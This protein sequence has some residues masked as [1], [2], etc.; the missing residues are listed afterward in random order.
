MKVDSYGKLTGVKKLSTSKYIYLYARSKSD[1]TNVYTKARIKVKAKS[2]DSGSSG[3]SDD[4]DSSSLVVCIDPGHGGSDDGASSG[5]YDEKDIN[6]TLAKLVGGYL[7]DA[8]AKVYYTRTDDTYVSL[9]DRTDYASNKGCNLF[10]SIHCNSGSS[11]AKG[12]E[13]YYS[14]KS[15][16]A[17]KTLATKISSAVSDAFDTTNRGAKTKTGDNGDYYSVIRTSA[18]KGIPA[19][20]VEHAFMTN[21]SDLEKLT[22]SSYQK[23]AAKAEANAI[24][25]YWN[26]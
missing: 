26:K 12:T 13:V 9:T 20:I 5:G 25:N 1:P 16:C 8:G 6:L 23:K 3:D 4:S 14:I 21:S 11:S 2:S 10:V 22:S 19:L 24:I 17:K 15:S 18:A 7:E